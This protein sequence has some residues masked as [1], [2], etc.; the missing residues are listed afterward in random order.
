M[1]F[2][3][4]HENAGKSKGLAELTKEL[5]LSTCP[6]ICLAEARRLLSAHPAFEARTKL[7][8]L[9]DNYGVK[10]TYSPKYHCELNPIESLWC[11]NK[12][13]VRTH[14]DQNYKTMLILIK[15]ARKDFILK[16]NYKK[17]I[18]R[19]W[20]CSGFQVF[21]FSGAGIGMVPYT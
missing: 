10:I 18:R 21:R 12:R 14:T 17:Y 13:Y 11:D 7:Q 20:R 16:K 4:D 19:F 5:N 1:F 8:E 2:G 6:K 15:E 3:P 9:A